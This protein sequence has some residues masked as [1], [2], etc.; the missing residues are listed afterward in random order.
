MN[1]ETRMFFDCEVS[2]DEKK[3]R[4]L[5]ASQMYNASYIGAERR[6]INVVFDRSIDYS[7][8]QGALNMIFKHL[9]N[10]G[11]VLYGNSGITTAQMLK[12]MREALN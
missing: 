2:F 4:K 11:V 10:Q 6:I 3:L 1:Q 9:V 8:R 12:I 7:K 5:L